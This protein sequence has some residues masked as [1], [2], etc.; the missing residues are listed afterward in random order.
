MSAPAKPRVFVGSSSEGL[1]TARAIQVHLGS[2]AEVT[3]WQDGVF[4]L[5]EGTLAS[6]LGALERFDFA[7]LV[8]TAD[9]VRTFRGEVQLAP[10]DNVLFELGLFLGRLGASRVFVVR[11]PDAELPSDYAGVTTATIDRRADGNLLAAVARASFLIA[12]ELRAGAGRAGARERGAARRPGGHGIEVYR[13]VG[14]L[15]FLD[16]LGG[17][18]EE[19]AE[20]T[21][22]GTGLNVLHNLD[23]QNL[24]VERAA[25]GRLAATICFG[26]PFAPAVRHR[27]VEEERGRSKPPMAAEGI[28]NLVRAMLRRARD[29]PGLSIRLFNNYPTLSIFRFDDRRFV[30][31]PMGYRKL[32]NECPALFVQEPGAM[33]EFLDEM[34]CNYLED[35][36][37]AAEVF[38]VKEARERNKRFVAPER[39]RAVAVYATADAGSD[40][41]R[42]GS[43]LLGYDLLAGREV[44]GDREARFFQKHAGYARQYGFHLTVCDVMYL[45]ASQLPVVLAELREIAAGVHRFELEVREIGDGQFG[46]DSIAL[47]CAEASGYLEKLLAEVTVHIRPMALGTNFSLDAEVLAARSTL[48]ARDRVMLEAYQSPYVFSRFVPHFTLASPAAPIPPADRERLLRIVAD[49]FGRYLGGRARVPIDR[50]HCLHKPVDA[51]FWDPVGDDHVVWLR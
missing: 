41:Y 36:V 31:Y 21:F 44:A 26:N 25:R 29:V 49:R 35:A 5:N 27:L 23:I 14:E 9:D 7:I 16:H 6:L 20:I 8:L 22:V 10:R 1:D 24:I 4:R 13:N 51:P 42:H 38:R 46:R 28:V 30:Y 2:Q 18:I 17:L 15:G 12:E 33:S 32:G 45:E 34:L 39:I 43:E 50:L 3:V 47:A 11:H 37:D 40:F 48:T 19:S